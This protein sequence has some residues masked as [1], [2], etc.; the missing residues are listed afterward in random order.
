M[1]EENKAGG[2]NLSAMSGG[3]PR[4]DTTVPPPQTPPDANSQPKVDNAD[5]TAENRPNAPEGQTQTES[6]AMTSTAD[7]AEV[8]AATHAIDAAGVSEA[9]EGEVIYTSHPITSF[10]L[11]RFQ[12]ENAVLRL[13][14]EKDKS[15]FKKILE[16]L[17]PR[18]RNMV[19]TISLD[20][21]SEIIAQRQDV[22]A[23]RQFDSS[24]GRE[25]MD[26]LRGA[27]PTVGREDISHAARP[28]EDHNVPVVPNAPVD[29]DG[30]TGLDQGPHTA[31]P[32]G[33]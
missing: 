25:A 7:A 20:R 33:Q 4:T 24:V 8:L 18:D 17:Q 6:G 14:N 32:A 13:T 2:L 26:V 5:Q 28:Q 23:T 1:A 27:I 19:R 30:K 15:D 21:V 3:A 10:K 11:G 29:P 22:L 9:D 12:F 31:P 16:A